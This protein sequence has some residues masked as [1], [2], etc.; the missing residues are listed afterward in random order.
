MPYSAAV[1]GDRAE[2][3]RLAGAVGVR[4]DERN[5]DAVREQH[6]EA[7]HAD[8]V[9]RED[10]GAASCGASGTARSAL[11]GFARRRAPARREPC[12]AA[13][14][15][16]A[17]RCGRRTRR[18]RPSPNSS[19]PI[20]KNARMSRSQNT[21]VAPASWLPASRKEEPIGDDDDVGGERQRRDQHAEHRE[22]LQ[23]HQR[24]AG[25][26]VEVEPDRACT[27]DSATCPPRARRARRRPRSGCCAN[28]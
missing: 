12:T 14:R 9:I 19:M 7:A 24:E 21:G 11:D 27:A 13:A 4:D 8:V 22:Q 1:V 15:G 16:P 5:F 2:P 23:R 20:R 3:D 18:S 17:G 25:D 28:V 6:L 26:E 10:D